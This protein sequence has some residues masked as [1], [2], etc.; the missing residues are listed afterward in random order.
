MLDKD[1]NMQHALNKYNLFLAGDLN[2]NTKFHQSDSLHD[3]GSRLIQ[4]EPYKN[5]DD[6]YTTISE[7]LSEV[8]YYH[9]PLFKQKSVLGNNEHFMTKELSKAIINKAKNNCVEWR[10]RE[11][12]AAYKEVKNKCNSLTHFRPM[13][14]LRIN[15][16]VGFYYQN[17]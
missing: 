5:C 16:V 9:A 15:Q 8:L 11:H 17:A 6:L 3:L 1:L 13:L 4:G 2:I 12:F 14:H 7:K 10:S